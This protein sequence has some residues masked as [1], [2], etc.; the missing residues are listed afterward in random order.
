MCQLADGSFHKEGMNLQRFMREA[1]Q[2]STHLDMHHRIVSPILTGI[3][4]STS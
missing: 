1:A 3:I 2:L 4:E